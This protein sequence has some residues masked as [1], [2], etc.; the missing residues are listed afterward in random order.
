MEFQSISSYLIQRKL[1]KLV[2]N[3][4][5]TIKLILTIITFAALMIFNFAIFKVPIK[6]NDKQIAVLALVVGLT[7]FYFKF[8]LDSPYFF[9]AQMVQAIRLH[10]STIDKMIHIISPAGTYQIGDK[11][12]AFLFNNNNECPVN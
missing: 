1:R 7:N 9:L 4:E 11:F 3:M 5:M 12:A 2:S 10:L 6:G 8:V